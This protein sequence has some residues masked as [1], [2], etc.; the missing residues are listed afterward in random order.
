[1]PWD[2]ASPTVRLLALLGSL[3]PE[4]YDVLPPH[5]ARFL[6]R[7]DAVSLNP[8][9]LPPRDP[10]VTGAIVMSRRL[11]ELALEANLR[12]EDS[13]EWLSQ[14]VDEWCG[15][16]WPRRWPWPG[17]GPFPDTGPQPDPWA[18]NEA[19]AVGAVVFASSASKIREDGLRSALSE[20]AEKLADVAMRGQ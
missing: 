4:A 13:R 7:F 18:L 5:S 16:P 14:I 1:M 19:R 9:P 8:Q 6:E 15:T 2:D 20:A 12:G 3:R 11:V 10:L 17:P